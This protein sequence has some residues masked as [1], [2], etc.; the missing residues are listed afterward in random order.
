VLQYCIVSPSDRLQWRREAKSAD[1]HWRHCI[2]IDRLRIEAGCP[3]AISKPVELQLLSSCTVLREVVQSIQA[4]RRYGDRLHRRCKGRGGRLS[5]IVRQRAAGRVRQ[6]DIARY[7]ELCIRNGVGRR[8]AIGDGLDWRG[9][10][11]LVAR[12]G[13][14]KNGRFAR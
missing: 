3:A 9:D 5:R 1:D 7:S 11:V 14:R 6:R 4:I 13:V 2:D 10:E 12:Y 8:K